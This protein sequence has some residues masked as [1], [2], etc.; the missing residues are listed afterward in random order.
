MFVL[1]DQTD[2]IPDPCIFSKP[3]QFP[4][5]ITYYFPDILYPPLQTEKG[6]MY[7]SE[8]CEAG[9]CSHSCDS[10]PLLW[11]LPFFMLINLDAFSLFHCCQLIRREPAERGE[12]ISPQPYHVLFIISFHYSS[13]CKVRKINFQALFTGVKPEAI[14]FILIFYIQCFPQNMSY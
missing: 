2:F 10:Q 8:S 4:L 12:E 6:D 3:I 1:A 14:F 9:G 11:F 5:K 7:I 13:C